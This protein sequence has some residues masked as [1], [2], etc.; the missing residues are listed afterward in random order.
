[1]T[2]NPAPALPLCLIL[3]PLPVVAQ[4]LAV[5]LGE[6]LRLSPIVALTEADAL[7]ALASL[8][9]DT[10][11]HLA[12][13]RCSPDVFAA[14]PLRPRI[15]ER[16]ALVVLMGAEAAAPASEAQWPW[17][18]L[19]WPFGTQQLLALIGSLGPRISPG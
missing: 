5:T 14:S 10:P 12:I 11:L 15:E 13:L 6:E 7:E 3:E 8:P 16:R 9:D 2:T 18:I 17:A 4:D 1:M 19:D